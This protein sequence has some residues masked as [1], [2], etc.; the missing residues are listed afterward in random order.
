MQ[1]RRA[2]RQEMAMLLLP[3]V[4]VEEVESISQTQNMSTSDPGTLI[5]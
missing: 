1:A 4:E 2:L 3:E 5:L